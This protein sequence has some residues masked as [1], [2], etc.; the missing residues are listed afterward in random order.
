MQH[1]HSPL[2]ARFRS[3]L[4][5]CLL[6]A[7]LFAGCSTGRRPA[8]PPTAPPRTPTVEGGSALPLERFHYVASLTLREQRPAATAGEVVI[9]TEGDFQSPDR[10]AFSH[11]VQLDADTVVRSAV[12]IGEDVWLRRDEGPWRQ[13]TRDDPQVADLLAVAFT[14]ARPQFL[15]GR[16]F[17][18]VQES[19]RRLPSTEE[20]VNGVATNHY[21]VGLAGREFFE[22]FLVPEELLQSVGDLSWD[23]WLAAEGGW[24]VRLLLSATVID[25]ITILEELDL[26]APVHWELRIDISRPNDPTLS[27]VAPEEES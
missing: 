17:Q 20:E 12:I 15:G 23:L 27:V 8:A 6:V 11:T 19:V 7:L 5:G 9:F 22:T 21:Q 13:T 24:P 1:I 3:A 2:S 18:Q 26:R 10:H 16:E 25:T 4:V 14:A